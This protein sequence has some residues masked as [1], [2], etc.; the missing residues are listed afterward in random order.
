MIRYL[1]INNML[2]SLRDLERPQ[3]RPGGVEVPGLPGL[4]LLASLANQP[5]G[6]P[7]G[8]DQAARHLFQTDVEYECNARCSQQMLR[9]RHLPGFTMAVKETIDPTTATK[10]YKLLDLIGSYL[11]PYLYSFGIL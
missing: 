1:C 6:A 4:L 10:K 3:G 7:H 2:Q 8:G 11:L 9:T 5:G